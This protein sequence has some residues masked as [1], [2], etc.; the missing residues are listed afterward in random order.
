M[1][2]ALD[3][4]TCRST[5]LERTLAFYED[6]LGLQR[7]SR[8]PF[9]VPGAWLYAAGRAVI[10]LV[11][12]PVNG[13]QGAIDHVAF[14]ARGRAA[15]TARLQAAGVPFD[16]VALPDGSAL[17]MFL[18]DPDGARLELVFNHPEDR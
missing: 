6:V 10:H 5:D 13:C 12:R 15:M 4:V 14:A 9:D 11:E 1:L 3:H 7:G 2:H 18:L 8:P 16:L 17:Q